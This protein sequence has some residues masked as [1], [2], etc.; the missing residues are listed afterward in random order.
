MVRISAAIVLS[1]GVAAVSSAQILP[2]PPE[3]AAQVESLTGQVAVMRESV[4]W[5]LKPGDTVAVRQLITTGPDGFAVFRLTDGSKFEVYPNSR[6]T[7]RNNPGNWRDLLDVW[8]GRVRV[9]IQ[10][11][12][13]QP[14]PNRVHTPSA[15]ISVRGTTFDVSVDDDEQA[16]LVVVEEGQVAVQHALLPRGDPKI[17]NAGDYIQVYKDV[18]LAQRPFVNKDGAI[19]HALRAVTDALYTLVYETPR[20]GSPIPGGSTGGGVQLPGDTGSTPP[21]DRGSPTPGD[22]GL[23]TPPPP[24]RP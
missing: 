8:L 18:P 17:L 15:V 24:P 16:T 21:P 12:G 2:A 9:H 23:A 1:F 14:N 4:P 19:R 6:V 11:L 13:G 10:K 20:T 5:A 22:V 7:F 3:Q